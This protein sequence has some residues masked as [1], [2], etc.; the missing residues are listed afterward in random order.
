Y[1]SHQQLTD[2]H[3]IGPSY[4]VLTKATKKWGRSLDTS[5][6]IDLL[7]LARQ[8]PLWVNSGHHTV[9]FDHLVRARLHR[10]R[11]ANAERLGGFEIDDQ[12]KLGCLLDWQVGRFLTPENT[13]R[14]NAG[15]PICL[16]NIRSI[17]QKTSG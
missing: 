3:A 7:G 5:Q 14:I 8:C 10:R 13:A 16:C 17:T 2:S 12:F 1:A 15:E 6:N 4:L 11:H 9:S